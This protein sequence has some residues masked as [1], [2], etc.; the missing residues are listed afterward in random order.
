MAAKTESVTKRSIKDTAVKTVRIIKTD[1]IPKV[2]AHRDRITLSRKIKPDRVSQGRTADKV[3]LR[4]SRAV[5]V[6]ITRV[7]KTKADRMVT[8]AVRGITM[9]DT[10]RKSILNRITRSLIT[11]E[12][13]MAAIKTAVRLK[14]LPLAD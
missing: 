7:R 2:R 1:K 6:S 5:K 14:R 10:T 11:V 4:K 13:K 3:P 9:V 8:R 12:I